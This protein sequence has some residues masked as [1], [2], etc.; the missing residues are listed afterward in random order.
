MIHARI[1]ASQHKKTTMTTD[2]LPEASIQQH[3]QGPTFA[4][5]CAN[6]P[7]EWLK[8]GRKILDHQ[9]AIPN[10]YQAFD[11]NLGCPQDI[12]K[13]GKYGSYLQEHWST[14]AALI[15]TLHQ[16]LDIPITAKIRVFEDREK[17]IAYAKM[18]EAAGAQV[19]TV[20]GRLREQRGHKTGLA[21]WDIIRRIKF[22]S[23]DSNPQ[24]HAQ[25]CW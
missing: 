19:L 10:R 12:A 6:D 23:L 22:C 9:P 15:S 24:K 7:Q 4:Q 14:I 25:L 16:Q 3:E 5:F 18:I 8:A 13:R 21:D 11:L 17:T 1:F 2:F 20:H